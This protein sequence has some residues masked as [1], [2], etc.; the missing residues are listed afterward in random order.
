MKHQEHIVCIKAEKVCNRKN[1]FVDYKLK[2]EDLMLGQRASLERDEDFRQLL[3]ISIFLH[4]GKVWAYERTSK[5]NEER[6]FNKVAVAVGGHWDLADLVT[7]NSVIDLEASLKKATERELEE[8]IKLSS[9][10]VESY[11]LER[12]ICADDTEVDKVHMAVVYVH[13]LDG[14]GIESAEDQLK[15]LGFISPQELL[16]GDYNLEAWARIICEILVTDQE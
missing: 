3:P 14:D 5:G 9:T 12:K 11:E 16:S 15:T 8:E 1:G 7:S 4:D 2:N 10:I 6:L 13:K